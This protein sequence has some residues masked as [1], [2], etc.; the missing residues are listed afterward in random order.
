MRDRLS[1]PAVESA[2]PPLARTADDLTP[3]WL[4]RVLAASGALH[5]A[6]V[7]SL[8]VAVLG[9]GQAGAPFG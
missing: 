8:D 4:T 3:E 9:T 7:E 1:A 2:M 6:S 5:D